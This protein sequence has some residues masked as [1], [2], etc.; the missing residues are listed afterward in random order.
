MSAQVVKTFFLM[1]IM[2]L[3]G[4]GTI[5]GWFSDDDEDPRQPSELVKVS[6]LLKIKKLWSIGI[7]NGQ[8]EGFYRIN[9]AVEGETIFAAANDGQ[10]KSIDRFNGKVYWK[11]D[12]SHELSGG[13]GLYKKNLFI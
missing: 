8:G 5:K 7:G 4:C 1:A 12:L 11:K 9:P 2:L 13:I 10:I 3:Q 6:S